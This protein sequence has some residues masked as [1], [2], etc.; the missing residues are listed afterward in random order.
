VLG[1]RP[2]EEAIGQLPIGRG[3]PSDGPEIVAADATIV[4]GLDQA[5]AGD[6]LQGQPTASGIGQVASEQ[7]PQILAGRKDRARRFVRIWGNNDLGENAGHRQCRFLRQLLVDGDDPAEGRD[8]VAGECRLIG[9]DQR[10]GGRHATG[11]GVL[12]DHTGGILR[13]EFG[14]QL[15]RGVSI[16][17]IVVAQF[18][19]LDLDGLGDAATVRSGR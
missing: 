13:A 17:I 16:V 15:E 1:H 10:T 2:G 4:A 3:S 9:L 18:L 6:R 11:I 19:A 8:R 5:T 7:Q 14:N 12:D